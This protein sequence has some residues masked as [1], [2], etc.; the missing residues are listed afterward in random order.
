MYKGVG[1]R[2]A[3]FIYRM[4][5]KR[6]GLTETKLFHLHRILKNGGQSETP[7]P[8]LDMSLDCL[9]HPRNIS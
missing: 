1:F 3:D 6:F 4:K 5:M 7:E 2:L 8:P 9:Y